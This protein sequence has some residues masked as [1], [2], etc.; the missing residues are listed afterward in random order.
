MDLIEGE[1]IPSLHLLTPLTPTDFNPDHESCR[2]FY[3]NGDFLSKIVDAGADL[4][5]CDSDGN[6]PLHIAGS[7]G[8]LCVSIGGYLVEVRNRCYCNSQELS[9]TDGSYII[10]PFP[11]ISLLLKNG[12]NVNSCNKS[13]LTAMHICSGFS[14][15]ERLVLFLSL[16]I[17]LYLSVFLFVFLIYLFLPLSIS[18]PSFRTP[19]PI[20][21]RLLLKNK[22]TSNITDVFGFLPIHYCIACALDNSIQ[23]AQTPAPNS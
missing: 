10:S 3:A 12:A 8:M 23:V 13:G 5:V 16:S 11:E 21:M 1:A 22:A 14:D 18:P 7:F 15:I 19:T 4:N 2:S 20:S 17:Y 6:Y 9:P